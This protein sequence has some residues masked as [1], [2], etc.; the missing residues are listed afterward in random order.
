AR[1]WL[2]LDDPT[3]PV[4]TVTPEAIARRGAEDAEARARR[5]ASALA[6]WLAA[7]LI[8]NTPASAYLDGRGVGPA[9]L[10]RAPGALRYHPAVD[11]PE[12]GV[13]GP[14]MIAA[15]VKGGKIVACH[16]TWLGPRPGG[17]WGKAPIERPKK[18]LGAVKGA[19][20][21]LWRGASG[22]PMAEAPDDDTLVVTEGIEDALTIALH[23]PENRVIAAISLNNVA[24]LDL[25]P[26][27]RDIVLAWDRDGENPAAREGRQKAVRRFANEG[28]RVREMWPP[29]G[30]KDW[31]AWWC[32]TRAMPARSSA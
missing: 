7:G 21:P 4:R 25:P 26:V 10:G 2:G 12:R 16:R 9:A 18:A 3:R 22:R 13:P 5:A 17:G 23:A 31:N 28:R 19:F 32:A 29:D 6:L 1:R 30:F 11:C 27:F 14:A 8:G 20:I 24:A 15:C